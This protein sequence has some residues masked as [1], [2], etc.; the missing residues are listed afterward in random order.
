LPIIKVTAADIAK[1]KNIE[2]GWY[3]AQITA[4]S[5]W[6]PSKDK[7]SQNLEITFLI[8]GT[9]GKEINRFYNSKAIGMIIPLFEAIREEEISA[10]EAAMLDTDELLT[11]QC[12]VKIAVDIYEGRPTNKIEGFLPYGKGKGQQAPF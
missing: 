12:D 10:G 11:K 3:S 8:D 6:K 7:G 2:A 4:I 1:N 9:D 5:P